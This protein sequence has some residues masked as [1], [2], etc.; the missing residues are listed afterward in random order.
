MALRGT[1]TPR[2]TVDQA[3]LKRAASL[4]S[5]TA[6]M[7]AS[8]AVSRLAIIGVGHMRRMERGLGRRKVAMTWTMRMVQNGPSIYSAEIYSTLED[9]HFY[10]RNNAYEHSPR[11]RRYVVDG[12][13]FLRWLEYGTKPHDIIPRRKDRYLTFKIRPG[14]KRSGFGG[15]YSRRSGRIMSLRFGKIAPTDWA[16]LRRVRHPGFAGSRHLRLTRG[17]LLRDA[18]DPRLTI[19]RI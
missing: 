11:D 16:V 8:Q 12:E 15:S 6:G 5:K 1:L 13:D 10:Q 14:V 9:G 2:V 3:S 7:M 19:R 4:A 17:L 18:Y